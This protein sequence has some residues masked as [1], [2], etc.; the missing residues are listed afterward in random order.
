MRSAPVL[1]VALF[2]ELWKEAPANTE[3]ALL[4]ED[5]ETA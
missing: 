1:D 2:D 5:E 4:E 3:K